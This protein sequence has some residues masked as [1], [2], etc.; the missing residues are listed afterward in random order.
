MLLLT[1]PSVAAV[2]V[3]ESGEDMLDLHEHG[4]LL[5]DTRKQD[6][7]GAWSRLRAGV[8][9]RLLVAQAALPD[10]LKLLIIECHRPVA[11]QRHYFESYRSELS[12]LNPGWPASRLDDEA[13]KHVS[14]PAVAPHP[15]GAAV[16]LTLCQDGVELDMGTPVNA[17]PAA[18]AN[19]CFTAAR[20]IQE[21]ARLRRELLGEALTGAGMV[22]YPPEWWHW[23]YGDRY[24]AAVTGAPAARYSPM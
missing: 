18:S 17:T 1:D 7:D 13:S 2:P 20:N 12:E 24:W 22:N 11:L 10:G 16:D 4:G 23:S 3:L 21:L 6:A 14:P 8:L 9:E 5:I 15:C 19:A